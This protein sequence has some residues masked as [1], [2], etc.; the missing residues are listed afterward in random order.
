VIVDTTLVAGSKFETSGIEWLGS[1]PSNGTEM[2]LNYVY[3]KTPEILTA[4]VNTAKQ[5]CTDVM[6][7]QA[8]YQ[9]IAPCLN[10]QYSVNYDIASVNSAINT[11]L[12]QYFQ[13]LG[14]GAWVYISS[15]CLAIQQVLGVIN[16]SLTT[17]ADDA[18]TY[19]VRIFE[20]SSDPT[21]FEIETG[22]F[23]LADN[24]LGEF[25]NANILRKATP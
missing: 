25:L 13:T 10:I 5:I 2:T 16:V 8:S 23:K 19:G 17:T 3:N 21:P 18:V 1:G 15:M 24:Q 6:I 12:Q 22:D 7:H 4:V 11:R 20:N 14:Y 9:Y